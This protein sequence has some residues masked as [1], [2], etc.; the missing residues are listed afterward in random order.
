[1]LY[2]VIIYATFAKSLN[3]PEFRPEFSQE[4]GFFPNDSRP[5]FRPEFRDLSESRPEFNYKF[6]HLT[7]AYLRS[8][9]TLEA[10]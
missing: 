10:E 2:D 5:E 8:G 3:L 4:I 9:V 1:M 7:G 6:S